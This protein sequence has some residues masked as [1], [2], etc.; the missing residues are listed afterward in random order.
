MR[1]IDSIQP[2]NLEP[3]S[4]ENRRPAFFNEKPNKT[5][6]ARAK[7]KGFNL[8][9]FNRV[10]VKQLV[11]FTRE[12]SVLLNANVP[13]VQSLN[14]LAKQVKPG[15]VKDAAVDLSQTVEGGSSLSAALARHPD[16]FNNLYVSLVKT[17]EASGTLDRSLTY[18]AD[19]LEKDYDLRRKIKGALTYP[20]FIITAMIGVMALMFTFVMPKMLLILRE[21]A[22]DLPFTTKILISITDLFTGYWWLM[23]ALIVGSFLFLR[24][25]ISRPAGRLVWDNFKLKIPVI[26]KVAEQVYMERFSRNF[27]VLVQGGVPLVHGLRVTAE[28]VGNAAYRRALLQA[29]V[30]V[31]NGQPLAE[32]L[33]QHSIIPAIVVQMIAVGEQTNKVDD[34]LFKMAAFYEK[35]SDQVVSNLTSLLEPVIMLALGGMVAIIVAGILLPIY[36]VVTA[37]Q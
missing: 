29:A 36:N 32:S 11:F 37:Q 1:R 14:I 20:A 16:V 26:G 23:I 8:T 12:L 33:G 24:F 3:S 17:G 15:R 27:A 6:P 25:Y 31:E 4:M 30:R 5:T 22:T 34:I 10:S 7:Q 9:F 2:I 21:T 28:A 18:L 19:Q 13:I 35:E